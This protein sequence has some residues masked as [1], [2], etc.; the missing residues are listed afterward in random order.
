MNAYYK[1]FIRL[2][3]NP[4]G[5]GPYTN[6]CTDKMVIIIKNSMAAPQ[7]WPPKI[8]VLLDMP[9]SWRHKC[10]TYRYAEQRTPHTVCYP[11][12]KFLTNNQIREIPL[13][14]IE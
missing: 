3:K 1:F 8:Q 12:R 11:V 14:L 6:G 2:A 10:D 13:T 5:S 9:P 4:H 7:Q